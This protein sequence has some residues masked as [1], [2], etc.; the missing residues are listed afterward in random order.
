MCQQNIVLQEK[1]QRA[2]G[3]DMNR[4]QRAVVNFSEQNKTLSDTFWQGAV[5]VQGDPEKFNQHQ[6]QMATWLIADPIGNIMLSYSAANSPDDI[7]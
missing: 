6:L 4:L 1:I 7:Y 3:K 2:L 5:L